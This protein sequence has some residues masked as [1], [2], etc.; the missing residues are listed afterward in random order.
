[1]ILLELEIENYKQFRGKHLFAPSP[2]GVVGIIGA[3]GA[4]KTTLFE[5]IEWCLYQPS[6]IRSAEIPPRDGQDLRPRVRLRFT[7]QHDGAIYELER[8]LG[9]TGA[10]AEVRRLDES[11]QSV[12]CNGSTAVSKFVATKLIGLPRDAFVATFFTRQKELS[13]FGTLGKA[14][15]R[16]EVNRLLGL[17]TIR[18]AQELIAE[19]KRGKDALYR[20]LQSQYDQE[21]GSRDF[22]AE[23]AA[24]NAELA[25][26]DLQITAATTELITAEKATREIDAARAQLIERREATLRLQEERARHHGELEKADAAI[27]SAREE[28]ARLDELAAQRPALEKLIGERP[29][30]QS[31]VAAL[32]SDRDRASQRKSLGDQLDQTQTELARLVSSARTHLPQAIGRRIAEEDHLAE[33]DTFLAENESVDAASTEALLLQLQ[34]LSG[35]QTLLADLEAKRDKYRDLI[36]QIDSQQRELLA[37]GD[38]AQA[39]IAANDLLANTRNVVATYKANIETHGRTLADYRIF[40][41]GRH[42][43]STEPICR[44]CGRPISPADREHTRRHAEERIRE[45]ECEIERLERETIDQQKRAEATEL[46]LLEIR[47][48]A[49]SLKTFGERLRNGH[50]MVVEIE[51][52]Q[53]TAKRSIQEQMQALQR[54]EPATASELD[55]LQQRTARERA[56]EKKRAALLQLRASLSTNLDRQQKLSA[57]VAAIGEVSFDP[58]A[59]AAARS[60]LDEA[61]TAEPRLSSI[62]Q[63]LARRA[64][65]T[66]AI[67]T[68]TTARADAAASVERLDAEIAANPIDEYALDKAN[69]AVDE[70]QQRERHLRAQRDAHQRARIGIEHALKAIDA[71]QKRIEEVARQ[72]DAARIETGEL[73]HM[74]KEFNRFEQFAVQRVKPQLEDMTSELVR[75]ITENKYESVDLDEDY[76]IKVWDGEHGAYPV[77]H[78]SGGERDVIALAA[79]LALSRLIGSQAAN[80]PSFLVLDEVFGSLDRD[81]RSNVLD[82]L[83]SLAGSAESF[84]QLF[85]ISHI[86]DVRLSPAFNEIWRVAETDDGASRL[87]NLNVTQGAED[88]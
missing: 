49:D 21:S 42:E 6:A 45:I 75:I 23:R 76:G 66:A 5:A 20:G 12:L 39:E 40:A 54:T 11:G 83:S 43:P 38:P 88:L 57:Q 8:K 33:I 1:M 65:H 67:E 10:I 46:D 78:F 22:G 9:K 47:N 3:N 2:T 24:R 17:E 51:Q 64:D 59:L 70:A 35:S 15:R 36:A 63:Q 77:E 44:M 14:D 27:R 85:V 55:E 79:R 4:G 25:D 53:E 28:L 82:L 18:S 37:K 41:D 86:D 81:R 48:R 72:A 61:L 80:P 60:A 34:A 84:Q 58:A 87:E 69:L 32:E 29:V 68:A 30:R 62:D 16:R 73:D 52:E 56:I 74:Y 7:N 26:I 71:D 50:Q 31:V 13:F 19:D